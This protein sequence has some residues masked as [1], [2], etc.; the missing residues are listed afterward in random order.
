MGNNQFTK[1]LLNPKSAKFKNTGIITATAT[2]YP[3]DNG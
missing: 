1:V 3:I 2:I